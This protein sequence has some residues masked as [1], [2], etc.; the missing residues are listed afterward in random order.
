[1]TFSATP[2]LLWRRNMHMQMHSSSNTTARAGDSAI[3]HLMRM[4][5]ERRLAA[6]ALNAASGGRA[7]RQ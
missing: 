1:M 6:Q 4:T 3:I 2:N 7:A 5:C